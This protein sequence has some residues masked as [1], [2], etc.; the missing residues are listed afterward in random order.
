MVSTSC[1]Q[2]LS[3]LQKCANSSVQ[4]VKATCFSIE[5]CWFRHVASRIQSH[6]ERHALILASNCKKLSR[7]EKCTDF[8]VQQLQVT[9]VMYMRG[10]TVFIVFY[11]MVVQLH[12][13]RQYHVTFVLIRPRTQEWDHGRPSA[14]YTHGT[15]A[16]LTRHYKQHDNHLSRRVLISTSSKSKTES[17]AETCDDSNKLRAEERVICR[18]VRWFQQVAV[19][20]YHVWSVLHR[21]F[22]L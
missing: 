18:D 19:D 7:Q 20:T 9:T 1:C 15:G 22:C 3:C 4:W 8:D 11:L 13:W 21:N 2:N 6:L 14:L 5:V 10:E 12:V 17:S 16:P